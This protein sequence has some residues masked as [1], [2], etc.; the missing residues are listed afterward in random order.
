MVTATRLTSSAGFFAGFSLVS[1]PADAFTGRT[2][3]DG[4]AVVPAGGAAT[5]VKLLH[6][7]VPR[8]PQV[9]QP[10]ADMVGGGAE[11]H[12]LV[13]WHNL[14]ETGEKSVNRETKLH[15]VGGNL[16]LPPAL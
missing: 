12:Q 4:N 6:V 5:G 10:G 9:G 11:A 15:F 7:L 13:N 3:Q 2:R 16:V 8:S 14:G 1:R